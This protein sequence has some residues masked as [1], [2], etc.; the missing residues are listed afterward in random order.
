[1]AEKLMQYYKYMADEQGFPGKLSLARETKIPSAKAALK[2]DTP[3]NINLFK[4]AVQKITGKP[5]P[6]Y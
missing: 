4:E 2:P 5:A 6:N 1:M 3:E